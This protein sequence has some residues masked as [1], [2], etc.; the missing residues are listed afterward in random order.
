MSSPYTLEVQTA[1]EERQLRRLGAAVSLV[2]NDLPEAAQTMILNKAS[3]ISI[4]GETAEHALIRRRILEFL[5][6]RSVS[7]GQVG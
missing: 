5:Q 6:S 2:W 1:A 7:E 3:A 4:S